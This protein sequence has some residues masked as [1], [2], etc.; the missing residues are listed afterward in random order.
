MLRFRNLIPK[1]TL[2]TLYK[3]YIFPYFDCCSTVWH[4]CSANNRYNIEALNK[5]IPRFILNDFESPYNVLLDRV[6][7]LLYHD[8]RICKFLTILYK[9]LFFTGYPAYMRKK[10]SFRC[11]SYNMRGHYKLAMPN[12]KSTRGDLVSKETVCCVGGKVKH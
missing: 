11:A 10:F 8:Q 2:V 4:F 6:N 12:P 7:C 9:S 1:D 5:R 3:A